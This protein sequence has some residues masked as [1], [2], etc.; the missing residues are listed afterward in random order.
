MKRPGLSA[1]LLL[2]ATLPLAQAGEAPLT[3]QGSGSYYRLQVPLAVQE[4]TAL[5]D[6]A[7][8][9]VL[10]ANGAAVPYAWLDGGAVRESS[11]GEHSPPQWSEPIA[12]TDCTATTCDYPLPRHVAAD[13][14][15][16]DLPLEN[17]L[18][19]VEWLYPMQASSAV[20]QPEYEY[21]HHGLR[22]ALRRLS[23]KTRPESAPPTPAT[24]Q[25][26][27][28]PLAS[29]TVWRLRLPE[30]E[31]RSPPLAIVGGLYPTLRLK[32]A[33]G[34][35]QLGSAAPR[36]R[37]GS[38]PAK[39]LFL[40]R[41]PPPYRLVWGGSQP[42]APLPLA[43]L[44]PLRQASGPLPEGSALVNLPNLLPT[45]PVAAKPAGKPTAHAVALR[46]SARKYWLWAVLLLGLG[47]MAAMAWSL[48]RTTTKQQE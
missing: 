36:L 4:R 14:L 25:N 7:D 1:A 16:L 32:V 41:E 18:A 20:P 35:A 33:A 22:H 45:E 19:A 31:T 40:A 13:F 46:P 2:A 6:L 42:G 11:I 3:L 28:L 26:E 23:G 10:D 34:I 29:S 43:Q 5:P 47:A 27:W 44:M 21:Q 9:Q 8:V 48:L 17:S 24:T 38:Q 37:V 39:I 15:A 30:G 12:P